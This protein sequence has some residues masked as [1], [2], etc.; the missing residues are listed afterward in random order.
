MKYSHLKGRG[1][2]VKNI[3][4]NYKTGDLQ[5]LLVNVHDYG[6]GLN[7]ENTSDIIMFHKFDSEIE[8]QVIGRAHRLGRRGELSVWYLLYGNE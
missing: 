4:N 8:K 7:L 1:D 6:S 5:V 3:V 2:V